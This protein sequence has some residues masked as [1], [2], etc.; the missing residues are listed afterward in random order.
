MQARSIKSHTRLTAMAAVLV[1]IAGPAAALTF[2][3]DQD[4]PIRVDIEK[5]VQFLN[6]GSEAV[7]HPSADPATFRV[8]SRQF[9]LECEAPADAEVR[10]SDYNCYVDG[11]LAAQGQFHM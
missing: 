11:V 3:N 4:E 5:W 8:E 1:T 7:F 10:I 2:H 9:R 6:A